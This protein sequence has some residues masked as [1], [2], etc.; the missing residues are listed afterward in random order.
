M[1]VRTFTII[2]ARGGSKQI[3]K[4]NLI[5]FC[6]KPLL[7]WSILQAKSS[8]YVDDVYVS[9]DCDEILNSALRYGAIPLKR[10]AAFATDTS[11]SEDA[12]ID[13]L[14]QVKQLKPIS[15]EF[16]VFLQATSPL[17]EPSDIDRCIEKKLA[18]DANAVFS[19]VQTGDLCAW[20]RQEGVL[21]PMTYTPGRRQPRQQG[22][23]IYIENGSIYVTDIE[24]FIAC[25]NRMV[26]KIETCEMAS[27]KEHEVDE[28]DDL[29]VCEALFNHHRLSAGLA[30]TLSN[31][32]PK[33]IVYDFDGVMTNNMALVNQDGIEAVAVNR[34]DGLGIRKI[35]Q[36]GCKQLVLS[37]EAN[38]VVAAR[39]KK[40]DLDV[41][42]GCEDKAVTLAEYCA[43][44]GIPLEL[45]LYVGNDINDLAVLKTTGYS[46]CPSDA[47]KDILAIVD[48]VTK[49]KGGEGV[50]REL[51]E[52]I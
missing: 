38:P 20:Q 9:S 52:L 5:P 4:K 16:F 13:A 17:R 10:P 11:S 28:R 36:T 32:K 19:S 26:G 49:A 8:K 34:S 25:K 12:L 33:L 31:F 44:N 27:W 22:N 51:S 43:R 48:Y 46:V 2:P 35:K 41:I 45:V 29:I 21:Q 14:L 3:P 15:Y 42:Y 6:G 30:T 37:T 24:A 7:A 50:I 1:T 18:T 39:A 47:H 40:L 23:T